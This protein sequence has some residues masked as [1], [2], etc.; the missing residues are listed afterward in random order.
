MASRSSSVRRAS[1]SVRCPRRKRSNCRCDETQPS[2]AAPVLNCRRRV[3][4]ELLAFVAVLGVI[5]VAIGSLFVVLAAAKFAFKLIFLPLK[6][7][8]LPVLAIVFL[9]KMTAVIAAVAAVVTIAIAVIVPL[10]IIAGFIA[11]PFAIVA[12]VA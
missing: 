11:V 7:L 9:V 1:T 4:F 3:M 8:F 10:V 12:A 5:G 6:L 2:P